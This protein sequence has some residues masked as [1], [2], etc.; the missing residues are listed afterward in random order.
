MESAH[1]RPLRER[2]EERIREWDI[3]VEHTR[4]TPTSFLAFG[5]QGKRPVVLKVIRQRGEEWHGGRVLA[6]LGGRGVVRAYEAQAGA[7]LLER[8]DPG[9]PL[10]EL[11][12]DGRDEEAT[13]ILADVIGRMAPLPATSDAFPGVGAWGRAFP[14]YE[15]TGDEQIPPGLVARARRVYGDLCATQRNPRLLHGD[16]HHY[17]VLLDAGRGWV[18]IDPKGVVG[19]VEFEVGAILRNPWEKPAL[20]AAPAV[21]ERRVRRFEAALGLDA[22]RVL[23]WGFAQAVLAAVWAVQDGYA[24]DATHPSLQVAHTTRKLLGHRKSTS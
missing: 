12:L 8:L 22:G 16:L 19:E 4:E 2:I 9:S 20:F 21:L 14:W 13:K 6:T 17:N 7:I 10:A 11:A 18:A 5:R 24:V 3:T 1:L 15:S 23:A